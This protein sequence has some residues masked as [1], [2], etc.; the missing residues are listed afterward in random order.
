M[1]IIFDWNCSS[2]TK[3]WYRN[4]TVFKSV[5]ISAFL[6][7]LQSSVK[8]L[9][10]YVGIS[11]FLPGIVKP[12]FCNCRNAFYGWSIDGNLQW[13]LQSKAAKHLENHH[14]SIRFDWGF[15]SLNPSSKTPQQSKKQGLRDPARDNQFRHTIFVLWGYFANRPGMH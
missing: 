10:M 1:P 13:K 14:W 11:C 7:L 2:I 5:A 9:K 6:G 12:N 4:S 8:M 15:P 3:S